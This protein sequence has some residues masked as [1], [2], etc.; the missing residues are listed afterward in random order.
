MQTSTTRKIAAGWYEL[1]AADGRRF[2]AELIQSVDSM[3]RGW[4]NLFEA[5]DPDGIDREW[6]DDFRTLRDAK[7]AVARIPAS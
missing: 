2:E 6:C 1:I 7:A 4:W 5:P 3:M